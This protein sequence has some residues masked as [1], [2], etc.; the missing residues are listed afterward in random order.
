MRY[1]GLLLA[2][3]AVATSVQ[4][5]P[6]TV[7]KVADE[8]GTIQPGGPRPPSNGNRF[9]NIQGSGNG[10]FASSGTL[11]FSLQDVAAQFDAEF[12][13]GNWEVSNVNIVIEQDPFTFTADGMVDVYHFSND[14]LAITNGASPGDGPPGEFGSLPSSPLF[15]ES[16]ANI[17][18]TRT[19]AETDANAIFG[20]VTK[21]AE[22]EFVEVA[23]GDL[24]VLAGPL[25][26]IDTDAGVTT[27]ATDYG[28]TLPSSNSS[29][30]TIA[31]TTANLAAAV[32]TNG[33]DV[34]ALASDIEDGTDALSLIL[35][36]VDPGVVASYKGNPFSSRF[37][38]RIYITA[39]VANVPSVIP[40]PASLA[41][42]GLTLA[43]F[44]GLRG[45]RQG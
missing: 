39:D 27:A 7:G 15:Y 37:P 1:V 40:E 41:I 21:I 17:L 29:G 20:T 13:A 22:Y 2:V 16:G 38:P 32:E 24:D 26:T 6:L 44:A 5:A 30:G 11:R 33:L 34:A 4:A 42:L 19:S 9:W 31:D 36:G 43:G 10:S 45:R 8:W 18:D 14:D 28:I 3:L 35:V 25:G 12:G 23:D